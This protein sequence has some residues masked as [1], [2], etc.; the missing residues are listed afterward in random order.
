MVLPAIIAGAAALGSAYMSASEQTKA[1]RRAEQAQKDAAREREKLADELGADSNRYGIVTDDG[2]QFLNPGDFQ[3]QALDA[4]RPEAESVVELGPSAMTGISMD[5]ATREA[6]MRALDEMSM[7]TEGDGMSAI[8]AANV[9][10]INRQISQA[11][12][13]SRDA[14]ASNMRQRG[15]EG[16]GLELAAQLQAQQAS[17]D[18]A[19][20]AGL[21]EAASS[22]QRK[23]AALEAL[24]SLGGNIRGQDFGEQADIAQSQDAVSRFN[25]SNRQDVMSRNVGARNSASES[26]W[27]NRQGIA[28][29]NVGMNYDVANQNNNIARGQASFGNNANETMYN[30]SAD[31]SGLRAGIASDR[32]N[33]A[34]NIAMNN[35]QNQANMYAGIGQGIMQG[36]NSYMQYD[37]AEKDRDAQYGNRQ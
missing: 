18:R 21:D 15:I 8:D 16:S 35:G 27:R 32:G 29:N 33:A 24:G 6:Q 4:Y 31:R 17:A 37:A 25:A 9:A 12:R 36:A 5:P 10:N 23:M 11:Q 34:S 13:G 3:Y 14:I 20:Q 26:D 2:T 7:M 30:R 1:A 22:M 19:S 28:N